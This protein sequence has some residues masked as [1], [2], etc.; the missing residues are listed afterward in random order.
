[1]KKK[2]VAMCAT[3][4][5]AAVAA[6]GTLAYFTD[7]DK[8]DNVMTI[9]NVAIDVK[10]KGYDWQDGKW[11]E[12][13]D[14]G[15][16][17]EEGLKLFPVDHADADALM[18]TNQS[19]NKVVDTYNTG[20]EDA[21]I[22]TIIAVERIP[23]TG[24]WG[25]AVGLFFDNNAC[26]YNVMPVVC[27]IDGVEYDV[28]VCTAADGKPIAKDGYLRT[29]TGVFL[30]EDVTNEVA[31]LAN[32]SLDIKVISQG[33]QAAGFADEAAALAEFDAIEAG[34]DLTELFS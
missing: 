1:M 16:S 15:I 6:G 4:A 13:P 18:T 23:Y 17:V 21:Y 9:G 5:I 31:Q 30:Y 27:E 26:D 22:R 24:V 3:V 10:E 33:I 34:D 32:G 29:L 19:Y 14:T 20:S 28:Y 7:I 25:S 11:V 2:I 8:A 12:Y